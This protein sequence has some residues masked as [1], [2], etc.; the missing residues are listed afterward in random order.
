MDKEQPSQGEELLESEATRWGWISQKR[1]GLLLQS[2]GFGV[3]VTGLT[4]A[5]VVAV[6]TWGHGSIFRRVFSA[7][8]QNL[9]LTLPILS[10]LLSLML[11][12][13]EF[14]RP[15]G[16]MRLPTALSLGLVSFSIWFVVAA[17]TTAETYIRIGS[18]KVLNRDYAVLL[19]VIAFIWAAFCALARVLAES[20]EASSRGGAWYSFQIVLLAGSVTALITPFYLFEAKSDVERRLN[21]SL[22]ERYFTVSIAY[23]DPSLNRHLGRVADPISQVIVFK[24]VRARTSAVAVT[25]ARE[26]FA[27]SENSRQQFNRG[28]GDGAAPPVEVLEAWVIAELEPGIPTREADDS[29]NEAP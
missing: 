12:I 1:R 9:P 6:T 4:I 10:A 23:R 29:A 8:H 25:R 2:P 17:Q 5:V 11:G 24:Q 20:T 22:D 27:A 7:L 21:Q 15:F 18:E 19:V 14:V 16:W 26:L 3:I 28:N 13:R